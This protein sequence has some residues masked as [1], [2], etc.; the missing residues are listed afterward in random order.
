LRP[1]VYVP[2]AQRPEPF[3]QLVVR[4]KE[5]AP[6]ASLLRREAAALD[7]QQP[8]FATEGMERIVSDAV[9]QRRFQMTVLGVFASLA[10]SLA[11][12]GIYGVT[13]Y[14]VSRRTRERV[15]NGH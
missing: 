8:V 4:S 3:L 11:A 6:P 15:L 5:S 1:T 12:I 13:A 7:S 10:V 9:A 14:G 2:L